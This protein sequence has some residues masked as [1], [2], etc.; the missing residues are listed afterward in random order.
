MIAKKQPFISL[1]TG[2]T[3]VKTHREYTVEALS[4]I[5]AFNLD[6]R[7]LVVQDNIEL[8]SKP[9]KKIRFRPR[10]QHG[11]IFGRNLFIIVF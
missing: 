6:T 5:C 1:Y 9:R 7:Q 10:M 8:P 4:N 3:F 2:C 11:T